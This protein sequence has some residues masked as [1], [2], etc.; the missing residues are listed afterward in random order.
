MSIDRQYGLHEIPGAE[1]EAPNRARQV[2]AGFEGQMRDFI[3]ALWVEVADFKRRIERLEEAREEMTYRLKASPREPTAIGG[4]TANLPP[5]R[6]EASR[7][8]P[9]LKP[10][11]VEG[12]SKATWYRRN[13]GAA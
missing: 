2:S 1:V 8:P 10:W 5:A 13:K 9:E 4:V 7:P 12:V 11:V 6:G 3:G